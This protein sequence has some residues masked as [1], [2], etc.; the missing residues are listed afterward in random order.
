MKLLNIIFETK[1]RSL[2][3]WIK[4]ALGTVKDAKS[5]RAANP[6][7]YTALND[8]IQF[9]KTDKQQLKGIF[10]QNQ[11]NVETLRSVDDLIKALKVEGGL[12]AKSVGLLNQGLLKSASTPVPIMNDVAKSLVADTKFINTYK[13]FKTEKQLR[14]ALAAKQYSENGIDAIVGVTKTSN[15]FKTARKAYFAKQK[16]TTK[17]TQKPTEPKGVLGIAAGGRKVW[18]KT[19]GKLFKGGKSSPKIKVTPETVKT[20][21]RIWKFTKLGAKGIGIT[22][23]LALGFVGYVFYD[24]IQAALGVDDLPDLDDIDPNDVPDSVKD[25]KKCI[26][27]ALEGKNNATAGNDDE[28]VFVRVDMDEF[29]G[30]KTGGWIQFYSDYRVSTKN[31]DTGKWECNQTAI[32]ELNEQSE[33][34][35]TSDLSAREIS[36][37]IDE[38]DDQLSGDFLDGDSTDMKDALRA[39][40]SVVGKTYKGVDAVKVIVSN[41]PKIKRKELADHVE[42]LTNLDFEGIEAKK[43]FL[44]IIGK[45]SKDTEGTQSDKEGSGRTNTSHLTVIWDDNKSGG[46]GGSTKYKP[47]DDF[48]MSVGCI[49]DKIKNIQ[50]CLNPTA[51]LK[52]DGYYGP[53]TKK[54][55][56]DQNIF[57]D[58]D[59]DDAK[60]TKKVYDTM[61]DNCGK[62]SS[63]DSEVV[64]VK[65]SSKDDKERE[66]VKPVTNIEKKPIVKLDTEAMLQK[67]G[68]EALENLKNMTVGGLTISEILTKYMR[69]KNGRFVIDVRADLSEDQLSII[70]KHMSHIN[71]SYDRRKGRKTEYVWVADSRDARRVARNWARMNKIDD[72]NS[73]VDFSN[74]NT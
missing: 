53:I 67:N 28:G 45:P 20:T 22:S 62:K 41:Y 24:L 17:P 46:S 6:R 8:V 18:D 14:D 56:L 12:T 47:C 66:T 65:K 63:G 5:L 3:E 19:V 36:R 10:K 30:K 55:M 15:E 31:G 38:L 52:V 40:K 25:W 74:A 43:E 23:L 69:F 11:A 44:Q 34:V 39:L 72:N 60:I 48:P 61:M 68:K 35:S 54:A 57:A 2:N 9:A 49:S 33:T 7:L 13:K 26:V 37:V 4:A 73:F 64:P 29:A 51:N 50:R 32:K 59:K 58:N 16:N 71:Y 42:N 70:N 27:D 1:E 21:S